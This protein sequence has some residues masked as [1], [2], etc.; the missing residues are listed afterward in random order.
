[1]TQSSSAE[2]QVRRQLLKAGPKAVR[3]LIEAMQNE[4]LPCKE[5]I[6]IARDLLNRGFGKMLPAEE[7]PPALRVVLA[8][9]AKPYAD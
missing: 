7:G 8:E 3:F 2:Q 1:M 9:E 6:E 5:R 4:E